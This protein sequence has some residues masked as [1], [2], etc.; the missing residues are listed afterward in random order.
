MSSTFA[1]VMLKTFFN[2]RVQHKRGATKNAG[3]KSGKSLHQWA[4]GEVV[5]LQGNWL[6]LQQAHSL[7]ICLP[8]LYF[9][10]IIIQLLINI[11]Y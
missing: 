6:G 10:A 5:S 7:V 3:R 1:L 9:Y 11:Y 8:Y 4:R 2:L